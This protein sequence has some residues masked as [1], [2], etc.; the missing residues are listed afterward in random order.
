VTLAAIFRPLA[1]RLLKDLSGLQVTYKRVTEGVYDPA[2]GLATPTEASSTVY[3]YAAAPNVLK[4]QAGAVQQGDILVYLSAAQLG[5]KPAPGDKITYEA[6]DWT[7]V[8][9]EFTSAGTLDALY[10]VTVRQA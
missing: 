9:V 6:T 8:D 2:T 3:A 1:T 5:F 4:L 7:V 10:T